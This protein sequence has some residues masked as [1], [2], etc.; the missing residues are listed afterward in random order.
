MVHPLIRRSDV[1][2]TRCRASLSDPPQVTGLSER[3]GSD[4]RL[5]GFDLQGPGFDSRTRRCA[6]VDV[7]DSSRLFF[8]FCFVILFLSFTHVLLWRTISLRAN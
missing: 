5:T 2:M 8:W 6:E 4:P 3:G 1:M 7:G